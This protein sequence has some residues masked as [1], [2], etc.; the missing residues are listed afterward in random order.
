[1]AP[2]SD[3]CI[4]TLAC[5]LEP[6]AAL[7]KAPWA[8]EALASLV[9]RSRSKDKAQDGVRQK[10]KYDQI[11]DA[12]PDLTKHLVLDKRTFVEKAISL[13]VK[14][15]KGLFELSLPNRATYKGHGGMEAFFS[16]CKDSSNQAGPSSCGPQER[17]RQD[18]VG[19][20]QLI[21]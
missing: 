21:L 3:Y 14:G 13:V 18:V 1:M 6:A 2:P 4:D 10:S 17:G 8:Q 20:D 7:G 5:G 12:I 19:L 15:C 16:L 9:L 11:L